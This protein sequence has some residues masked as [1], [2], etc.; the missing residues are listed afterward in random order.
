MSLTFTIRQTE[1]SSPPPSRKNLN[2]VILSEA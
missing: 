2:R 1:A